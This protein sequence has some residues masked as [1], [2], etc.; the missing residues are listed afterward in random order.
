MKRRTF[1]AGLGSAAA[2]PLAARAQQP[3]RMR[4]IGVLQTY[5]RDDPN[6]LARL[7][8]FEQGLQELGWIVG[9]DIQIDYR[10]GGTDPDLYRKYAAELVALAPEVILAQG[11]LAVQPL[12]QLT[13]LVPIVFVGVTDPV[14]GGFAT[15]QARPGGTPLVSAFS[16][17]ASAGNGWACSSRSLRE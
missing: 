13:L 5:A 2:W 14:G 9:R 10:F 4:R 3:D 1:I 12:L 8:A 15:T 6:A 11:S 16:N 17:G 7:A